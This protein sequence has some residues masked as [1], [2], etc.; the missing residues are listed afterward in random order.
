MSKIVC[1]N[2]PNAL[3]HMEECIKL[4]TDGI[5]KTIQNSVAVC[6]RITISSSFTKL[7]KRN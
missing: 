5:L 4:G 1:F 7:V 6:K 3:N 2:L